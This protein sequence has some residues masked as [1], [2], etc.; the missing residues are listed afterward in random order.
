MAVNGWRIVWILAAYDMPVSTRQARHMYAKF[1]TTL[2]RNNF[3]RHQFSL[4]L[5]HFPTFA[6]AQAMV[7]RLQLEIP[8][9]GKV[10]FFFLT[11]KQYG[12]TKRFR[13]L[14]EVESDVKR[15]KQIELF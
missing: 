5:R 12:M 13:G 4:Y 10:S 15:P 6:S 11:D 3:I 1:R 14:D 8:A 2:L 7:S 9:G